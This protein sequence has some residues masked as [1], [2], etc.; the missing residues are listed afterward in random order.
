VA[1][2][3][4]RQGLTMSASR[5]QSNLSPAHDPLI[6]SHAAETAQ[7]N[8]QKVITLSCAV[9]DCKALI[10]GYMVFVEKLST[11]NLKSAPADCVLAWDHYSATVFYI[12]LPIVFAGVAIM[13]F[14]V[15]HFLEAGG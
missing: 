4:C 12:V 13:Y 14:S 7:H 10:A 3:Y 15:F 8:T 5:V 1:R 9:D 2:C 6:L 11:I